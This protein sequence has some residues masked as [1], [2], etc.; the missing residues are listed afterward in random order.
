VSFEKAHPEVFNMLLQIPDEGRLTD[1]HGR[2]MSFKNAVVIMTSN[3]G[4][5]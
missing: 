2:T 5:R 4:S 1:G 3:I